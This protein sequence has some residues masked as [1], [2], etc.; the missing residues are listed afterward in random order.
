MEIKVTGRHAELTADVKARFE[1]KAHRLERYFDGT[2]RIEVM[3]SKDA[4]ASV[5]DLLISAVGRKLS[6]RSKDPDLHAAFD[7]ALDK[8]EKQLIRYKEKLHERRLKAAGEGTES[9]GTE[10]E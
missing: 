4:E 7:A 1:E 10:E 5:V 2:Y 9:G 8:A 3:I 6:S